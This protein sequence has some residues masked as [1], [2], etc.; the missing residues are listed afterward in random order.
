MDQFSKIYSVENSSG[1]SNCRVSV[2]TLQELCYKQLF[3]VQ[4][5]EGQLRLLL[6]MQNHDLNLICDT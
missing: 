1:P 3:N 6:L 2:K 5:K 4:T